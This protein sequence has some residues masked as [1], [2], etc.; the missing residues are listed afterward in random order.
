LK[1][2]GEDPNRWG[3]RNSESKVKKGDQAIGGPGGTGKKME[4]TG[5]YAHNGGGV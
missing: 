4:L 2:I 5:S 3:K 1:E